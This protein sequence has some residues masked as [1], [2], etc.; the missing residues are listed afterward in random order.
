MRTNNK[1]SVFVDNKFDLQEDLALKFGNCVTAEYQYGYI[2]VFH[3]F[4]GVE[5]EERFPKYW[6]HKNGTLIKHEDVLKQSTPIKP[7]QALS[8]Y[9]F[10]IL[11][12]SDG[13]SNPSKRLL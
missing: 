7:E 2:S 6:R 9:K 13:E 10:I 11:D 8:S 1:K 12:L 5:V 3:N 4:D